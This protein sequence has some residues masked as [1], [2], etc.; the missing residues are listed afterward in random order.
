MY[1]RYLSGATENFSEATLGVMMKIFVGS[2]V[3][4]GMR[5]KTG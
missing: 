4:A 2:R 3:L 5:K 1:A